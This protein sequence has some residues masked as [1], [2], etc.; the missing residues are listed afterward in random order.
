[1]QMAPGNKYDWLFNEI[2][3][4][5]YALKKR[6]AGPPSCEG[7]D[8]WL[9]RHL[10]E[11]HVRIKK[12]QVEVNKAYMRRPLGVY[13]NR[14]RRWAEL[15]IQGMNIYLQVEKMLDQ[16]ERHWTECSSLAVSGKTLVFDLETKYL[17]ADKA[18][19]IRDLEMSYGC[20]FDVGKRSVKVY[21]ERTVKHLIS[22]LTSADTVI[23]FNH[24]YFDYEVLRHYDDAAD[25]EKVN[26]FDIMVDVENYL[27]RRPSLE[28][29]AAPTL[30]HGK[31]AEGTQAVQWY[32]DGEHGKLVEY[33]ITDVQR[34]WELFAHGVDNGRILYQ[35]AGR[36]ASDPVSVPSDHWRQLKPRS[37]L[38]GQLRLFDDNV[39]S[40][41]G[42]ATTNQVTR[43]R[44]KR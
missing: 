13:A 2:V 30:G 32:W 7:W 9:V 10:P 8:D 34:T 11:L 27:H 17:L 40:F 37:A 31:T 14:V 24:I 39:E 26:N 29:L 42:K 33:M 18:N 25:F 41:S 16:R 38:A 22:D 3:Q 4:G 6:H 12:A 20:T 35:S 19:I 5:E 28:S 23:G 43:R 1:M 21:D 15:V 44:V 36:K